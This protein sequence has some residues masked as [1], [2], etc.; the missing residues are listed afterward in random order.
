[1]LWDVDNGLSQMDKFLHNSDM[2]VIG[3]ALLGIGIMNCN[4]KHEYDPVSSL[5]FSAMFHL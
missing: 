3:G 2:H 4:I 5:V 1:M